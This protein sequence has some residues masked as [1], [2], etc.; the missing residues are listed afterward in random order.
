MDNP[1]EIIS[2]EDGDEDLG[3]RV[4]QPH[5][6]PDPI[7]TIPSGTISHSLERP[8]G[9]STAAVKTRLSKMKKAQLVDDSEPDGIESA[10]FFDDQLEVRAKVGSETIPVRSGNVRDMVT[11]YEEPRHVDLASEWRKKGNMQGKVPSKVCLC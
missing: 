11:L 1:R 2:V 4:M 6:S 10:N 5:S 8:D 7:D 3:K 9:P